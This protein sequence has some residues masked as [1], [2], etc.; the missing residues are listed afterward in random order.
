MPRFIRSG[1]S[2][3]LLIESFI[4]LSIEGVLPRQQGDI[5]LQDGRFLKAAMLP[6]I[7]LAFL[8]SPGCPWICTLHLSYAPA[9]A[10]PRPRSAPV[11][12]S[13]AGNQ[14]SSISN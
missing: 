12:R 7:S 3:F 5:D 6:G 4:E 10:W 14:V 13:H 1:F 9:A 2:F 11:A 8:F